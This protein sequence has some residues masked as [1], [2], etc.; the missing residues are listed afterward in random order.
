MS[1][2]KESFKVYGRPLITNIKNLY[3]KTGQNT[4]LTIMGL[5]FW[6]NNKSVILS[7][8]GTS[9]PYSLSAKFAGMETETP[10]APFFGEDWHEVV[11]TFIVP[12]STGN[13]FSNSLSAYD[14]YGH[15]VLST[16]SEPTLST[17]YPPFTGIEIDHIITSENNMTLS[18]PVPT[19]T[20]LVDLIIANRAGY[21]RASTDIYQSSDNTA[22]FNTSPPVSSEGMIVVQ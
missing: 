4:K 11:R 18:L 22:S 1:T 9:A 20:G 12:P 14:L 3:T 8:Y 5:G 15:M 6:S 2:H 19:A 7:S 13:I 21:S 17:K 16:D 10:V